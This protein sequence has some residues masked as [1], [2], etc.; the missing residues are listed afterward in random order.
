[1]DVTHQV[2]AKQA[3]RRHEEA[4]NASQLMKVHLNA[5][6]NT[7]LLCRAHSY[8]GISHKEVYFLHTNC[9]KNSSQKEVF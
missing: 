9:K 1:M 4:A 5:V 7:W 6:P 2:V 3:V 8:T